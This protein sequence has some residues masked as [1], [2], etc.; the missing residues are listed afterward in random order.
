MPNCTRGINILMGV[1]EKIE[2]I[3][4]KKNYVGLRGLNDRTR[5]ESYI[6]FILLWRRR[7]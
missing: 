5:S 1:R 2:K 4:M 3:K 6:H 7:H